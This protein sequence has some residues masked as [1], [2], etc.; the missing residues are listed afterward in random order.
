MKPRFCT[1]ITL[2]TLIIVF[3]A[4]IA[5][6]VGIFSRGGPGP[7]EHVSVHGQKVVLYGQGVYRHMSADVA[8]QGIAQDWVTLLAG[9]PLLLIS[10]IFFRKNSLRGAILLA[11]TAFYFLVTYLFY[12]AMAMYNPLYLMYVV[13]LSCS[14]FTVA[15]T[16]IPLL[17]HDWNGVFA[18]KTARRAGLFMMINAAMV[19]LLWLGVILPPLLDGSIY[20]KDLQHYTTLI[21]QGFDL[22]LLLPLGALSGFLAFRGRPVGFLLTSVYLLFLSVLMLALVSKIAFMG[23]AGANVVP[24]IFIMPAIFLISLAFSILQLRGL[25]TEP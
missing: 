16:M 10:L 21:V 6:S 5:A 17:Q 3:L 22:G 11:G 19:A 20:P 18:E 14:F 23:H 13:L 24:V 12:L 7:T 8:I 1:Q 4:T 2:M 25:R 15:L 9:V